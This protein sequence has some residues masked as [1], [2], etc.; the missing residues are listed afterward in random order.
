MAVNCTVVPAVVEGVAGLTWIELKVGD[1][2]QL[3]KNAARMID[4]TQ[5]TTRQII[6]TP[7]SRMLKNYC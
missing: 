2:E 4:T 6:L 7:T 1:E 5:L 3:N